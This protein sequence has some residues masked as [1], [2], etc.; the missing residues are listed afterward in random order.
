LKENMKKDQFGIGIV[1]SGFNA[2]HAC[3]STRQVAR[4]S[5][6]NQQS[7]FEIGRILHLKSEIS[8]WTGNIGNTS[9]PF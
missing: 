4:R 6:V 8:N 1:G 5:V 7:H 3:S 2:I 9:S